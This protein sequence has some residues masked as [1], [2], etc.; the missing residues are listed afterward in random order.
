MPESDSS[1]ED[2]PEESLESPPQVTNKVAFGG[3]LFF[4]EEMTRLDLWPKAKRS[5]FI[6]RW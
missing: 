3:F 1:S 5:N 4:E 2:E 6:S